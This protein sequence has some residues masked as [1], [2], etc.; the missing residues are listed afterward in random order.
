MSRLLHFCA[1]SSLGSYDTAYSV[2]VQPLS[3]SPANN[4]PDRVDP[5]HCQALLN[6]GR[7]LDDK[8]MNW[9]PEGEQLRRM[10]T[11]ETYI[12]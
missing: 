4:L 5:L 3:Y 9:Q 12:A 11:F 1:L 6:K 7:W 10:T 8:F 2:C